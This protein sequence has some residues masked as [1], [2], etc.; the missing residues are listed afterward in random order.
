MGLNAQGFTIFDIPALDEEALAEFAK[1]PLDKYTGSR[2]RYRRYSQFRLTHEESWTAELL[3]H[4]EF[5]QSKEYN[6]LVGGQARG[7]EPLTVV[8]AALIS[9]AAEALGL[10]RDAAWQINLHQVRI[11]SAPGVQGVAVPEGPHRDGHHYT[12]TAVSRRHNISGGE[13]QLMPSGGGEP[14]FRTVLQPGQ[15]IAL[16]DREMFHHATDIEHLDE[17]GGLRDV[18][19]MAVNPWDERRYGEE[20]EAKVLQG[21]RA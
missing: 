21:Q 6:P 16:N 13:T 2:Q 19:L 12:V 1:L 9:A 18:W 14:F 7:F 4:R 15:A 11:V 3:P 17:S 8:P 5:A 10:D 20:W